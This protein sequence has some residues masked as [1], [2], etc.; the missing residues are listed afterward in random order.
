[1]TERSFLVVLHATLSNPDDADLLVR[2]VKAS[3]VRYGKT[4]SISPK[5]TSFAVYPRGHSR[6]VFALFSLKF[7]MR[8]NFAKAPDNKILMLYSSSR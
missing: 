1:M 2:I 6:Q 4:Y 7:T 8:L 3:I 5:H